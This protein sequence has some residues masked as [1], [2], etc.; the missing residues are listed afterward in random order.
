MHCPSSA[1][2]L[3]LLLVGPMVF[4][5]HEETP[6][7]MVDR[8]ARNSSR[9]V[10]IPIDLV[11][12]I[13]ADY[14][15]FLSKNEVSPKRNIKRQ[16]LN[17]TAELTQKGTPALHENVRVVTPLGGGIVDLSEFVTPLRGSFSLKVAVSKEDHTE[18]VGMRLFYV[19]RAKQRVIEGSD[20]GA[21][22]DKFMEITGF[23]G[24]KA[25]AQ[26]FKLY[27]AGQ[28]YISVVGGTFVATAYTKQA[29]LVGS[30]TIMDSRYP[31]HQCE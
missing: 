20:F 15:T 2:W 13:E 14:R 11:T 16:F 5:A 19:S 3:S 8:P 25:N 22:C 28:R 6:V 18:P 1:W 17:I 24:A 21:G 12:R 31:E 9:D 30:L 10:K 23:H 29:L 7:E 27:T 26:G 4:A